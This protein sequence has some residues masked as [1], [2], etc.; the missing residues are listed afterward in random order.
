LFS[1][2]KEKKKIMKAIILFVFCVVVI[3]A[4]RWNREE[5]LFGKFMKQHNK[6]YATTEEYNLRLTNF[7]NN[8][9]RNAELTKNNGAT[10]GIN[11]F[12]DMSPEEFKQKYLMKSFD[13]ADACIWPYH[14]IAKVTPQAIPTTVDWRTKGA[15]SPVKNQQQCGSCWT[16]STAENIEGQWQIKNKNTVLSLSEQWVVDCSHACLQSEPDLCNG[17]CGGGLPWLAYADIISN[18]GL[19]LESAY[20]YTGEQGTCQSGLPDAAVISN[21]TALS[22]DQ[23]QIMTY[24]ANNGPLSITLNAGL[25]FSY[26]S[27]IITGSPDSCPN[28]GSDHAVLL[29]GYDS[30]QDFWIV[31]NSWGSDW[32]EN[33]YFRIAYDQGLCGIN[34][35]VTSSIV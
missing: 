8:L 32:G 1:S 13:P 16:F 29:V 3:E 21:W 7:K 12:S 26:S 9:K 22:T 6:N 33:G 30:S 20:P 17:G 18:K 35:C 5:M 4:A 28:S 11:K 10:F 24:L 15:V 14:R 27:G 25:L 31:K 23:T 19:P 2:S 34:S